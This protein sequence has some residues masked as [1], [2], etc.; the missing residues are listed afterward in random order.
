MDYQ[1]TTEN[2]LKT[3][4]QKDSRYNN[5]HQWN[6]IFAINLVLLLNKNKKKN[7]ISNDRNTGNKNKTTINPTRITKNNIDED[8]MK[9]TYI[10][11]DCTIN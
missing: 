7:N 1:D 5:F 4:L 6:N 8:K 10:Q 2:N 3:S 9:H 11:K